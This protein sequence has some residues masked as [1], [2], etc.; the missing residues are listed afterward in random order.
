MNHLAAG[1]N[2]TNLRQQVIFSVLKKHR[3][4]QED[5]SQTD[6]EKGNIN[7]PEAGRESLRICEA[8]MDAI[9]KQSL[10]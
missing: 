2:S 4:Q 7:Y 9:R 3:Y 1:V 5:A 8:I 10:T 6:G